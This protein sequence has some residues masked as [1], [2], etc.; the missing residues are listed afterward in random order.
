MTSPLHRFAPFLSPAERDWLAG[1]VTD[2]ALW[3]LAVLERYWQDQIDYLNQQCR[4]IDAQRV[5]NQEYFPIPELVIQ[6]YRYD[7]A[8]GKTIK[9]NPA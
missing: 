7:H 5:K 4:I 8:T 9:L 2:A 1:M 3:S 6:Y